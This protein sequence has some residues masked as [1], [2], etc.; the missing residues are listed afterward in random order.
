MTASTTLDRR[1]CHPRVEELEPRTAP[2]G[3]QPSA[4]ETLYLERLNDARANPAAYGASIG[5]DL[6]GV[7]PAPPLAFD[8]TLVFVAR[9]HSQDEN[10]RG[11]FGHFTPEGLGPDQR[12]ASAGLRFK[13]VEE[14]LSA[15]GG[16][17]TVFTPDDSLKGLIIDA[18]T[19]DLGHRVHLLALDALSQQQ[20]LVGIGFVAGNGPLSNFYTI[21]TIAPSSKDPTSK[22]SFIT[23][24]VF[25]DSNGNGRYD[26][27]EGL[28]GV[29]LQF[30]QGGKVVGTIATWDAGGY[31]FK[32]KP[33]TY[34]VTASGGSLATP[35]TQTVRVGKVNAH[36][37]F[38]IP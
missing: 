29:Q 35:I 2:V 23:G 16:T 25:R 31:S 33:G 15:G 8:L 28:G 17:M 38:V 21:D 14:S 3:F 6:S 1:R 4:I 11:Y 27:G 22:E 19:P 36:L 5:L 24:A 18:D 34:Q 32:V 7:L 37:D 12:V 30:R 20:R 26:V 13:S 10:A 9:T